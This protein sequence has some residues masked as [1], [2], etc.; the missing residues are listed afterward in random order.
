MND[1]REKT[2]QRREKKRSLSMKRSMQNNQ[3][4]V[5]HQNCRGGGEESTGVDQ[6]GLR[7]EVPI[8]L[9]KGPGLS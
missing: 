1:V 2:Q 8:N 5:N 3:W 6:I 4:G 9:F 7:E